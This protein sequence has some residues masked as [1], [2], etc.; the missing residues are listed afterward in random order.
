MK[1][2]TDRSGAFVSD[3]EEIRRR[4]REYIEQGAVTEGYR[5][6]R[7]AVIQILNQAL[8]TEL[9]CGLRYKRHFYMASGIHA[10]AV[11][12]EFSEHAKEEQEHADKIA[13]RITQLEGEPDF[14]PQGLSTETTPSMWR[15]PHWSK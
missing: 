9:I 5:T 12:D 15:A 14:N 8:A 13:E 10:E 4:A 6:V 2:V 1:A 3:M 11:V 7:E